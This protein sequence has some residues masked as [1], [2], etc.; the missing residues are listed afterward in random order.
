MTGVDCIVIDYRTPDDLA[1]FLLSWEDCAGVDDRLFVALV[2][3]T[4]EDRQVARTAGAHRRVAFESNEGFGRACNHAA[5][6]LAQ[7]DE[8]RPVLGFFNADTRLSP[9]ILGRCADTL[10]ANPQW[11][12]LG[13]RQVDDYGRL[14]AAGIVGTRKAPKHRGWKEPD[15]GQF[16]DIVIDCP[17]VAGSA[18]FIKTALWDELTTCPLWQ[19][20]CPG[21]TGAFQESHYYSETFLCYHAI[22]HGYSCVY[23]GPEVMVHRWHQAS[24][25]GGRVEQNMPAEQV[26]FRHLCDA[27]HGMPRD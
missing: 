26:A 6:L 8:R 12:V 7:R 1:G 11:G 23:Y 16:S 4:D 24:P 5:F 17:T 18:L 27:V 9:G 21:V 25:V 22:S 13:P 14:T 19:A 15:R 2:Q 3:P 20:A 10:M